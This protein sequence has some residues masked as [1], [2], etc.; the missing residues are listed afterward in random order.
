MEEYTSEE[1]RFS[2]SAKRELS[3]VIQFLHA[4][5]QLAFEAA[6]DWQSGGGS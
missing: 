4:A 1:Y 6:T 3:S 2:D 5:L